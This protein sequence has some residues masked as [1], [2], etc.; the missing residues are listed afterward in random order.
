L[1]SNAAHRTDSSNSFILWLA[2]SGTA[3]AQDFPKAEGL[4]NDFAGLISEGGSLALGERL[5]RLEEDTSDVLVVV[6]IA[7][8]DTYSIED[9]AVRLFEEWGIGQKDLDNGV[10]FIVAV[11]ERDVRI[12]VGY[13]LEEIITMAGPDAFWTTRLYPILRTATM[14]AAFW[15][16]YWLLKGISGTEHRLLSRGKPPPGY[17]R[18]SIT[19]FLYSL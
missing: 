15:P 11:K 14:K 10:L 4:V 5:L 19:S 7:T 18:A 8:L 16:A 12:E 9:Y 17:G 13:G 3:L 1:N 2:V 6:T